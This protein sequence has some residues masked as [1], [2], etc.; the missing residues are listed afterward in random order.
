MTDPLVHDVERLHVLGAEP[1][2]VVQPLLG[3]FRVE[4]TLLSAVQ[5]YLQI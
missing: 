1:L 2:L 5:V 3:E 4:V